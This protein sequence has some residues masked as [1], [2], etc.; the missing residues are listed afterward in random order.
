[1]HAVR[2][3]NTFIHWVAALGFIAA[4]CQKFR[5]A[6]RAPR[7][8]TQ[9]RLFIVEGM[10]QS[11]TRAHTHLIFSGGLELLT[12]HIRRMINLLCMC[13]RLFVQRG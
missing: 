5:T 3:T 4:P 8:R 11:L 12:I 10:S 7:A 9:V 13:I 6:A 1:M 2:R